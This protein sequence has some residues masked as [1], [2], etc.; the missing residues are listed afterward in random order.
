M[1]E[2]NMNEEQKNTDIG[3]ENNLT[4]DQKV[5]NLAKN[6]FG[7]IE[8]QKEF[9]IALDNVYIQVATLIEVLADHKEILNPEIWEDKLTEVTQNI[10]DTMEG[11][12]DENGNRKPDNGPDSNGPDEKKGNSKIITPDHKIIIPGQWE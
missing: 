8:H 7:V 10:K 9:G 2:K 3:Q 5:E 1:S 12:L 11:I 6:L 4:T